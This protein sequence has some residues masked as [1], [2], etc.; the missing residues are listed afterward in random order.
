MAIIIDPDLLALNTD[1]V[2]DTTNRTIEIKTTG[3]VTNAGSTGG[4]S[5]QCLYSWLKE[6]WKT[7]STFIRFP[8]PMLSI[9]STQFEFYNGWKPK[10]DA[11]RNLIRNAGWAEIAA[12]G[13]VNR[14][15]MGVTSIGSIGSTDQPYYR[16]NTG[17]KVNFAFQGPVN[18]SVQIYGDSGN[19]NF[20]YTDGDIFYIYV[21][22]QGKT[23]TA[24]SS[25][26]ANL[27]TLTY[28]V[29]PFALSNGVDLKVTTPDATIAS[30][31]P[32]NQINVQFYGTDQMQNIDGTP[33]AYRIIVTDASG[34]ATTK[35]IYEKIQ[36]LLRQ[37]ADIDSGSGSVI[38]ST[39]DSLLSFLGDTLVGANGVFISGLNS[40]Y[41]NSV[42]FYDKIGDKHIYPFVAAGTI[43][44]GQYAGSGDFKYWMFFIDTP[45]GDFGTA[46][47]IIVK[48]KDGNDITGTYTGSP[49]SFTFAYDTNTQGGRTPA[50]P[51]A[52]K[53]IGLGLAGGQ[54]VDVDYTITR[55]AGQ[56]ILLAPAQ[57]RNYSNP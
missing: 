33:S 3:A 1:I 14:K 34:V 48:D 53:V 16:W 25:V 19:G 32:W 15:Y 49:V 8:P 12:N 41:L 55:Q 28:Q 45:T 27:A 2:V 44:F 50:T 11:T 10:N 35:Q 26:V 39:A 51:A 4:V 56:N 47:A 23:Y 13:T 9:T 54:Y 36:Y 46:D 37:D 57:E 30:S 17:A 52:V 31:A 5:G 29:Y 20:D 43:N 18:Q 40:N 6:Q 42:E 22:E 7:N 21:R 24:S 38:G